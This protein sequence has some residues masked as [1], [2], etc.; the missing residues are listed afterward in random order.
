MR[1]IVRFSL[2]NDKGSGLRNRLK[3]I[4]ENHGIM[5]TGANTGTYEGNVGEA[6]LR[7]AM[8]L[9]WNSMNSYQGIA[10]LDHFWMYADRT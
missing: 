6:D 7:D 8:R 1:V 2:N 9:F 10:T 4:L 3:P 5:W